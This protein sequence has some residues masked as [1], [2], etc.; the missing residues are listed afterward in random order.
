MRASEAGIRARTR[1]KQGGF[2]GGKVESEGG[3]G[4][5]LLQLEP[6][7]DMEKRGEAG[8]KERERLGAE[9]RGLCEVER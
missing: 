7:A 1:E 2:K 9:E 3:C 4:P 5:I 6:W 8:A